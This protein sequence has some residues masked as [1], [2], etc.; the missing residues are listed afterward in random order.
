MAR[1][2]VPS[3][4]TIRR[5][6]AAS[7]TPTARR[8]PLCHRR[9]S[10]SRPS[11][12]AGRG[13]PMT[14]PRPTAGSRF[15]W[16]RATRNPGN[17]ALPPSTRRPTTPARP[18][19]S[20]HPVPIPGTPSQ[21]PPRLDRTGTLRTPPTRG[22]TPYLCPRRIPA[23]P[24]DHPRLRTPFRRQP[25]PSPHRPLPSPPTTS[26]RTR[27]GSG[28]CPASPRR[29]RPTRSLRL[30]RSSAAP[31][32]PKRPAS[33][34]RPD[35]TTPP[36]HLRPP[37]RRHNPWVRR[38]P[39]QPS[40]RTSQRGNGLPPTPRLFRRLRRLRRGNPHRR[41]VRSRRARQCHR[42]GLQP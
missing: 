20:T 13:A 30:P 21:T 32:F 15:R 39:G 35:A 7:R 28:R 16:H 3:T 33:P 36:A 26:P 5:G 24:V 38:G 29:R 6:L 18:T 12:K 1:I 11:A 34:R 27:S 19:P 40:R 17:R 14:R 2:P 8:H 37:R 41:S 31:D 22:P 9:A 25:A 10:A 4:N 42:P 23:M